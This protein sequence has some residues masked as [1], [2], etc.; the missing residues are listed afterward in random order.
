MHI[1]CD[2][3]GQRNFASAKFCVAWGA[4]LGAVRSGGESRIAVDPQAKERP[5]SPVQLPD[6]E[7]RESRATEAVDQ[8]RRVA[9][10]W[11]ARIKTAHPHKL[12]AVALILVTV[13]IWVLLEFTHKPN[14]PASVFS[15]LAWTAFLLTL[16]PMSCG[17]VMI[18]M[19]S[20]S[21]PA[22]FGSFSDWMDRRAAASRV[23]P[24]RFNRFIAR[25]ALW[26]YEALG[27]EA[28]RI[29]DDMLRNGA[30]VAA[31][32]FGLMLFGLV[33]FWI[34]ALAITAVLLFVAIAV[35]AFF[36]KAFYGTGTNSSG[37]ANAVLRASRG[38]SERKVYAG[39]NVLTDQVAGRIDS[40]GDVF[41]G[42][43]FLEEEKVGRVDAEGN[44]YEGSNYLSEKKT[45]RTDEN[46]N[47]YEGTNFL[48]EQRTGRVDEDGNIYEG[49]NVINERKVGRIEKT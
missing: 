32:A 2:G 30:K 3:C 48:N 40:R 46:G 8:A 33:L 26:S 6:P 31:C 15:Y 21:T 29:S 24:G 12:L 27:R 13:L 34:A 44:H 49:T 11:R 23:S 35:T 10:D 18:L 47:F 39:T 20:A 37:I 42:S 7:V 45:G 1:F 4:N 43:N 5:G 19:S 28:G 17:A 9:L 16:V 22:W 25:P 41:Q 38:S 14:A 36:V